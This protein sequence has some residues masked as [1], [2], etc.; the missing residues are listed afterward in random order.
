LKLMMVE[1]RFL[2]LVRA[3]VLEAADCNDRDFV[4]HKI[5]HD[6]ILGL[7]EGR[8]AIFST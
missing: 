5:G 2:E 1:A 6:Q 8:L 3:V 7:A 4:A